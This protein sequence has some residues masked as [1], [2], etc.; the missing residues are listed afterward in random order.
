MERVPIFSTEAI[1][2]I[3]FEPISSDYYSDGEYTPWRGGNVPMLGK[4]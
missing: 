3:A 1:K 2:S 4:G